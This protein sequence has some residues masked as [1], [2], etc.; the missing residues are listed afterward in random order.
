MQT[1]RTIHEKAQKNSNK[2]FYWVLD[3]HTL[4]KEILGGVT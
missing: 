2:C 3:S 4:S 1:V